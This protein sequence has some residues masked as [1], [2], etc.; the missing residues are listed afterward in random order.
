M[1]RQAGLMLYTSKPAGGNVLTKANVDQMWQQYADA[2][3]VDSQ[4]GTY[5]EICDRSPLGHCNVL[6]IMRF[7]SNDFAAYQAQVTSDAEL[8]AALSVPIYPDGSPVDRL[9][10]FGKNL[11]EDPTTGAVLESQAAQQAFILTPGDFQEWMKA[12]QDAI[13]AISADTEAMYVD[14]LT[15]RSIDDELAESIGG[16]TF[17]MVITFTIMICFVSLSIGR[18]CHRI[19][20]RISLALAG[21]L[22]IILAVVAA[23]GLIAATGVPFTSLNQIAPFVLLGIGVDD[24][25]IIVAAF[26]ATDPTLPVEE[27]MSR[28][29]GRCGLSVTYT[30]VTDCFALL[31]GSMSSLP[32]VEYFCYYMGTAI[33][34]DY[35]LQVTAFAAFLAYDAD[36]QLSKRWDILCCLKGEPSVEE[37]PQHPKSTT[38]EFKAPEGNDGPELPSEAEVPEQESGIPAASKNHT[39]GILHCFCG[40]I[41][42]PFLLRPIVKT[43]VMLLAVSLLGVCIWGVTEVQEG[44]DVLDLTTDGSYAKSYGDRSKPQGLFFDDTNLYVGLYLPD[45]AYED[46]QV[47]QQMRDLV[48]EALADRHTSEPLSN[49]M[50]TFLAENGGSVPADQFYTTL[51]AWLQ[52]PLSQRF[53]DD[54]VFS[55]DGRIKTSRLVLVHV[56][57]PD[58][59]T[60]LDAML[61]LRAIMD[62]NDLAPDDFAFTPQYVFT[63]QFVVMFRETISNFGLVLVAVLIFSIMVLGRLRYAVLAVVMVAIVD[64]E[65]LASIYFWGLKI[66]SITGIELV[67]AVGLV[68]D[69]IVHVLHYFVHQPYTDGIEKRVILA[70]EEIG[71]SIMLGGATTFLGVVP[72]AFAS[73]E[74]FRVFF[75][76]VVLVYGDSVPI[77]NSSSRL[78]LSSVS[79]RMFLS[80][81][82][83][84]LFHGL[85]VLPVFITLIP[86]PRRNPN[87]AGPI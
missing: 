26:E 2:I 15:E 82:G 1:G 47:Q 28:A 29:L 74:I 23:Y 73:N 58:T 84:G 56:D 69:Y 22:T 37:A 61:G 52:L 40:E 21:V 62:A 50:E 32:A 53:Q 10:V 30:S 86:D 48:Q 51:T 25:F 35:I 66:N 55:E 38:D 39:T 20:S 17:L 60:R 78:V 33:I 79:L 80:I 72:L 18:T 85:V 71:P 9:S 68:V 45:L 14:Y 83:F 3:A 12:F 54:I 67:M 36:R 11:K 42:A 49:W 63:E 4:D 76:S 81:V 77:S 24:M 87:Q 34:F 6:G 27:R 19:E 5:E 8:L 64:L 46:P 13:P 70:L 65:I 31:L 75:R 43:F 16:E 59:E 44:F 57:T 41:Y 7:W